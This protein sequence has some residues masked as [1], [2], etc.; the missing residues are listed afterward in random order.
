MV[1]K[2]AT[3]TPAED[4]KPQISG[5]IY[6]D[7]NQLFLFSPQL[8]E[9]YSL[10]FLE[11]MTADMMVLDMD[12]LKT[13][14]K[15]WYSQFEFQLRHV[16]MV[17]SPSLYF[18][19]FFPAD[20]SDDPNE[21]IQEYLANIPFDVILNSVYKENQGHTVISANDDFVDAVAHALRENKV[22]SITVFPA[23][24]FTEDGEPFAF[25]D[26]TAQHV[27]RKT[28]EY[29]KR[30]L[31]VIEFNENKPKT[32]QTFA[33]TTEKPKFSDKRF[34]ALVIV[35]GILIAILIFLVIQNGILTTG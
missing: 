35:F 9:V 1:E 7:L 26:N 2:S 25:D 28:S 19:K 27:I 23:Y 15:N 5:V 14:I 3:Q 32:E 29:A 6:V 12:L 24:L 11:G 33:I 31:R 34:I 21:V 13:H 10:S 30:A 8:E 18:Q 20:V 22:A 4:Q 17:L 16:T